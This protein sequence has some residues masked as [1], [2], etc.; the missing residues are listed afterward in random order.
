MHPS[1]PLV[2]FLFGLLLAVASHA[3]GGHEGHATHGAHSTEGAHAEP[4][5][6]AGILVENF[7]LLDHR[8]AFHEL[9][10][11]ADRSAIVLFVHGNGC[12]IARHALPVLHE[13]ARELKERGVAFLLLNANLQDDRDS[14]AAEAREW[15]VELPI[16]VDESQLVAEALGV[17]RTAEA[18]VIDPRTWR[19]AYRGPVDDRLHYQTQRPARAHY[20][21]DA[22]EDVLAGREVAKPLRDAAGCLILFPE[23]DPAAHAE[24]SYSETIAP[25]LEQRCRSCHRSGGVAPWAMTGYPMVRGWSPMMREML[26]T[27]RM[28][29][30]HAD[31]DVSHFRNDISLDVSELRTLVH[32]IEAGAPRGEGPD[33]LANSPRP[34]PP[35]WTHGEPD[36]ILE[37][38]EQEIPPTGVVPYRYETIEL[39][40]EEDLFV[41]GVELKPSNARVMHH[42]L[43]WIRY[44]KGHAAPRV[45]GPRFTRG[46]FAAYVPGRENEPFPDG[47]GYFVPAGSRL[48]FQLHYN[49]TGRAETDTPRLGLYLAEAPLRHELKTGSVA[50]FDFEIPPGAREHEEEAV[51]EIDRDILIYRLSPHMH[52]R[53]KRMSIEARYPDGRRE[54]LL[55]VPRYDFNWQRQYVLDP[56]REI[57]AGSTLHVRA[58]FDNS[59]HNPANP[60]PSV[61]VRYGEQTFEEMLFGYFLY[62]DLDTPLAATD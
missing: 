28:P 36:W 4:S 44:P 43:A 52:L 62:R 6:Q 17:T 9:R 25:L 12:P 48:R 51:A 53:G 23:A 33:P 15:Q 61:P 27:K 46:M 45:Q 54:M 24:I 50:R 18:I 8:G 55:S 34:P 16:L 35:E 5:R 32:W 59:E 47:A 21:R 60:D 49:S 37:L 20:L 3:E 31:P 10:G 56:P 26:R 1:S 19:V 2:A 40:T 29:P 22:L 30:W 57:P 11:Y 39:E 58:A 14:I 7:A 38:P 42:G 13:L 41:R